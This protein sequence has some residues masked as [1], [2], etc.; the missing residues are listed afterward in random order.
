MLRRNGLILRLMV[1][2]G[3]MIILVLT[4]LAL[5]YRTGRTVNDADAAVI[6]AQQHALLLED[7][8]SVSRALQRD[9][10]NL[11][12]EPKPSE[13]SAIRSRFDRRV[14]QFETDLA[15][16]QRDPTTESP[17]E[18][19]EYARTQRSV[20]A[21][22]RNVRQVAERDRSRALA[23]FGRDVRPAE[24]R[25]SVI[26]DRMIDRIR[27]HRASLSET[28]ERVAAAEWRSLYLLTALFSAIAIGTGLLVVVLT[29]VRPLNAIRRAMEALAAGNSEVAIPGTNRVDAVGTMARAIAVFRDAARERDGLRAQRDAERAAAAETEL[30]A[31]NARLREAA[32]VAHRAALEDQRRQLLA[33][34]ADAVESSLSTVNDKLRASAMRL[35]RS[36]DDVARYAATAGTEAELTSRSAEQ[37]THEL[38][39]TSAATSQMAQTAAGLHDTALQATRAVQTAVSRSREAAQRVSG[40]SRYADRVEELTALIG[41]VSEQ[42]QLLALNATIEA[43]RA[44]ET[45]K[46]FGVVANEMKRLSAQTAAAA[47]NVEAELDAIRAA[48]DEGMTAIAEIGDAMGQI[49]SNADLVVRSIREHDAANAEVSR[50]VSSALRSVSAVGERMAAL[51]N[52]ALGTRDV[53]GTLLSDA[54]VLSTDAADV[55]TALRDLVSRLRAA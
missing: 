47:E 13:L 41:S 43:A 52:T 35:N 8:R 50:G 17:A 1:P 2:L 49:E 42:S 10:L 48:A 12:T 23:M 55:D 32:Q 36:A 4:V 53:A 54:E 14:G 33:S 21:S 18:F 38:A 29:V 22:L 28:A 24:R 25:A 6:R 46:G 11:V 19:T 27:V 51:G 16:L 15:K 45:G 40:M 34:L 37:V 26:A 5:S 7:L 31:G 9:A 20:L 44:G 30:A 3:I 39:A